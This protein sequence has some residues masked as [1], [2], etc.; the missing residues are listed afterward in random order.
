M[1]QSRNMYYK[2]LLILDYSQCVNNAQT[3]DPLES[4]K[5]YLPFQFSYQTF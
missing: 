3:H 4:N 5:I 2:T 1:T